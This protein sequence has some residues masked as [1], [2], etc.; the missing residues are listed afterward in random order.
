MPPAPPA[1]FL[2]SPPLPP[3]TGSKPLQERCRHHVTCAAELHQPQPKKALRWKRQDPPA[4]DNPMAVG[5]LVDLAEGVLEGRALGVLDF[6][7]RGM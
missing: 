7:G 5:R 6:W 3:I 1:P 4:G 2:P